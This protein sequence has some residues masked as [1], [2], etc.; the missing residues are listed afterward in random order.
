MLAEAVSKGV[1]TRESASLLK[2]KGQEIKGFTQYWQQTVKIFS[3]NI[4]VLGL[5]ESR[6]QQAQRMRSLHGLL[7]N[8]SVVLAAAD[9]YSIVCLATRDNDFDNVPGVTVYKPTDLP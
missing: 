3:L 2:G 4:L 6:V 8:D 9:E 5:E 1:I 7:T